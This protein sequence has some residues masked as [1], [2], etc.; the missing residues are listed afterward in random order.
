MGLLE[1]AESKVHQDQLAQQDQEGIKV[2]KVL[3]VP[4]EQLDQLDQG[5]MLGHKVLQELMVPL[6]L[7]ARK[8]RKDLQDQQVAL[9]RQDQLARLVHLVLLE[10]MEQRAQRVQ[11]ENKDRQVLPD[12]QA[13]EVNQ[14]VLDLKDHRVLRAHKDKQDPLDK[15]VP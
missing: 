10:E 12:P 14:E 8:E 11:E 6:E 15:Q 9:A 13:L 2:T 5:E 4:Q 1:F 3:L 7:K